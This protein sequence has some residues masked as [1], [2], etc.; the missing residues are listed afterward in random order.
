MND[1][2]DF[3]RN[4]LFIISLSIF[5]LLAFGFGATSVPA[6]PSVILG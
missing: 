6:A 2:S 4:Y 1:N 3:K 5:L